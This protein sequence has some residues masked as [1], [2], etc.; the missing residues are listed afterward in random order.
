MIEEFEYEGIWWLPDKPKEQVSGTLKFTPEEGATLELRGSF[1]NIK[2][3]NKMVN[4]E[5][6]LGV[7]SNGKKIT[8]YKCSK[9]ESRMYFPSFLSTSS[10]HVEIV[11]I[12][13][14]FQKPEDIKFKSISVYYT[15]LDEWVG[16]SMFN[17]Q[18]LPDGKTIIIRYKQPD[19]IRATINDWKI[20][21]DFK[22]TT[23]SI[24]QKANIE[25]RTYI[26]IEPSEEKSLDEYWNT[27]YH[28]R[29]FLTLGVA[30]PVYPLVIKGETE[31]N[32]EMIDGTIYYP[33]VEVFYRVPDI[34]RLPETLL[35]H[36]MLF[37][38]GDISNRFE[39]FLRNWF[40]KV[41]TLE[42][43]YDLYFGTLY[44]PHMY[45]EHQFLS[46]TQA[47]ESFHRR[48]SKGK[49]LK[50]NE[51]KKVYD[52][53]VNAIP[54]GVR[55]D[56]KDRL[57]T[58]LKY[59]NEFSLRKRLEEIFDK[60]QEVLNK[61]IENRDAFIK[62]VVNTRNYQ[63]HYDKALKKYSV[64]KEELPLVIEKLRILLQICL[65]TELGF[66]PEEIKA[67]FAK[68]WRYRHEFVQHR[69]Q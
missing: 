24:L 13:A 50:D 40:N 58:Y 42:P 49:Y 38:F 22:V 30:K 7:S 54:D 35:P 65:L 51:Y 17:I 5:I 37:T 47:V 46:L 32:K 25:Q 43:V 21:L 45:I 3:I 20:I 61:F 48:T 57:K 44:N 56:L 68:N 23:R 28:I 4:S 14:H 2:N 26:R 31:V 10:C 19:P 62:K 55:S 6:I 59:G 63:T 15:H 53:L 69:S 66:S 16:I 64:S 33:P 39:F 52:A 41:S 8:L 36:Y 18:H 11:F 34:P 60:Y 9:N 1:K 27:I 67:L 29:N 12:G